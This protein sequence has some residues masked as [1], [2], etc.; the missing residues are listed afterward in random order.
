MPRCQVIRP[1][2]KE[3]CG[4]QTEMRVVFHDGDKV[5]A[6]EGCILHLGQIAGEVHAM[7]T[8]EKIDGPAE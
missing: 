3:A 2:S 8:V 7:V 6:C 4:E 5:P 1:P